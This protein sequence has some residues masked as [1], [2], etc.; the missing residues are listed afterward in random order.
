MAAGVLGPSQG[1]CRRGGESC[2]SARA[3]GLIHDFRKKELGAHREWDQ[4]LLRTIW[5]SGSMNTHIRHH[6]TCEKKDTWF[7]CCLWNTGATRSLGDIF[8]QRPSKETNS[9]CSPPICFILGHY[10]FQ[11]TLPS[12]WMWIYS[13]AP[14]FMCPSDIKIVSFIK[15]I[16]SC[17]YL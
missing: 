12:L 14:C 6:W 17:S 7:L 11:I 4:L 1:A 15:V 8:S 2:G 9:A 13:K 5:L 10:N 3:S 16:F